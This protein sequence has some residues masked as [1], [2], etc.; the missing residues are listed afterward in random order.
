MQT[1]I[2][3]ENKLAEADVQEP[4]LTSRVI[5]QI[6][7]NTTSKKEESSSPLSIKYT[8]PTNGLYGLL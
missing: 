2:T 6:D 3:S 1:F 5:L 7:E 8:Y 4:R